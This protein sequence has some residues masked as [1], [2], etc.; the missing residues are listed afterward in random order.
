MFSFADG[1]AEIHRWLERGTRQ[2]AKPE[3]L[4]LPMD[5][6]RNEGRDFSWVIKHMSVGR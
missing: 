2:P 6:P 4:D 3:T 5:V 1:H